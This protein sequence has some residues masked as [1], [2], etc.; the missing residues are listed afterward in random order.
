[1][2]KDRFGILGDVCV[3]G[4]VGWSYAEF[5]MGFPQ[6]NTRVSRGKIPGYPQDVNKMK[7]EN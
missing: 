5:L 4:E 7:Q 2:L 3:C 1:M 6:V